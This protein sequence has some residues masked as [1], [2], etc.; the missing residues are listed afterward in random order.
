VNRPDF[1]RDLDR[2]LEAEGV[3][4]AEARRI[5]SRQSQESRHASGCAVKEC[6][7]C[8]AFYAGL[9]DRIRRNYITVL[10]E[11]GP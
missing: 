9:R 7:R 2:Q 3:D 6:A 1:L 10:T 5:A 11:K 4:V 8:D